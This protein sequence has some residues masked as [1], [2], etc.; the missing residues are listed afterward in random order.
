LSAEE[1]AQVVAICDH[2]ENLKYS[3]TNPHAFTE[4]GAI[5]VASVLNSPR[6]IETSVYIVRAFVKLR[7]MVAE[8]KEL[9]RKIS[10]IERQLSEH[11]SDIVQL[12]ELIENLLAPEPPP[13]NRRIGFY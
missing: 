12:V 6:A 7:E 9:Q 11:D 10:D 2:L 1:K 4:H 3:S 13:E 8:Q 5:M